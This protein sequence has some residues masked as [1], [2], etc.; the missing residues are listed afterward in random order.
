VSYEE[1]RKTLIVALDVSTVAEARQL[2]VDLSPYVGYFKIGLEF[3][4]SLYVQIL[5]PSTS[6]RMEAVTQL[7]ELFQVLNGKVFWDGKFDDIPN[8]VAGASRAITDLDVAM[9]NVHCTGGRTMMEEAR[10]AVNR[11]HN[12]RVSEGMT[13]GVLPDRP[14]I[15]GVTLLTSLGYSDLV[16][17]NLV[18]PMNIVDDAERKREESEKVER[19][20]RRWALVAQEA[21]LDGVV[22]SPREIQAI[23]NYCG[24]DFLIV[25]PG[26]RPPWALA[27]DQKRS[28]SATEAL[29]AGANYLVIGRPI[30]A[31]PAA[32][33]SPVGAAKRILEEMAIAA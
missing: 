5:S 12:E 15:L 31:P 13:P 26:I 25:T 17:L 4:T 14:L 23:R 30:T 6:K 9:F 24:P 33:G 16:D 1:L 7:Y 2:V 8:T 11:G 32:I 10:L 20:V 27:G 28:M 21:G 29:Q 3:L 22:A 18:F 19:L